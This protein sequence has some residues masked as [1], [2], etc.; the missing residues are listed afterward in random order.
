MKPITLTLFLLLTLSLIA[1]SSQKSHLR[2]SRKS[3]IHQ[4]LVPGYSHSV[5]DILQREGGFKSPKLM[6]SIPLSLNNE[7]NTGKIEEATSLPSSSL[8][9]NGAENLNAI[10]IMC[11]SYDMFPTSC[12]KNANCGWCG[13]R[14][15]CI[16]GTPKGPLGNCL[17]SAYVYAAPSDQW[18][19]FNSGDIN[20]YARDKQFR[21][22]LHLAPTPKMDNV[23]VNKPYL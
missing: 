16:A 14:N 4:S 19:P 12:V 20:L 9:Y 6:D 1:Y 3:R 17:R 10:K 23:Y 15:T 11:H 5:S 8:Y 13:N 2:K 18:N 7:L 22:L 21:P